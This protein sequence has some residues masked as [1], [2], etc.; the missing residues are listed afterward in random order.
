MPIPSSMPSKFRF[1]S[2]LPKQS[3][4]PPLHP[5]NRVSSSPC[6]RNQISQ[7]PRQSYG[8]SLPP[9]D[10]ALFSSSCVPSVFFTTPT[11]SPRVPCLHEGQHPSQPPRDSS[12]HACSSLLIT[13][14]PHSLS[15][16]LSTLSRVLF[17]CKIQPK[18][19]QGNSA[20]KSR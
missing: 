9:R 7:H 19:L 14:T 1:L 15:L 17:I 10:R 20:K 3:R 12:F 2:P 8:S 13:P 16:H 11:P 6:N 4:P 5:R 18:I